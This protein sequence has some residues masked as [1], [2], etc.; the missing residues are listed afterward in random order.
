MFKDLVR[1]GNTS[2]LHTLR[3]G[4]QCANFLAKLEA[5]MDS[6]LSNHATPPDGLLFYL[7]PECSGGS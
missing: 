5:P 7:G 1:L 6:A 4:N 2:I 3:E